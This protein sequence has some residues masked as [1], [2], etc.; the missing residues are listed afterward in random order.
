MNV[1][2]IAVFLC[3]VSIYYNMVFGVLPFQ[4][5]DF[6]RQGWVTETHGIC[7]SQVGIFWQMPSHALSQLRVMKGLTWDVKCCILAGKGGFPYGQ[8][9][10]LRIP[11]Y[12]AISCCH[13]VRISWPVPSHVWM[14]RRMYYHSQMADHHS[15]G[16][17]EQIR[18][19]NES[20]LNFLK[21]DW[22]GNALSGKHCLAIRP[23]DDIGQPIPGPLSLHRKDF[24]PSNPGPVNKMLAKSLEGVAPTV[25]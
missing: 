17:L 5:K 25:Q 24:D 1:S 4:T 16:P 7:P 21:M 2:F 9:T 18:K 6:L 14:M 15:W 8:G 3:E 12:L 19:G 13:L 22:I 11:W 20:S 23:E 10:S